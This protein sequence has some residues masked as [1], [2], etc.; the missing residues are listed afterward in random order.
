MGKQRIF[1]IYVLTFINKCIYY[2]Q[3]FGI[4]LNRINRRADMTTLAELNNWMKEYNGECAPG[5]EC[6][7]WQDFV[8]SAYEDYKVAPWSDEALEITVDDDFADYWI[9]VSSGDASDYKNGDRV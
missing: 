5:S 6:N 1:L 4:D 7:A 2:F 3:R 8:Q 9:D